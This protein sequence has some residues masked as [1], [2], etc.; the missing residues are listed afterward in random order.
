MNVDG[1]DLRQVTTDPKF[2]AEPVWSPD[3]GRIFF[4]TGRDRNFEIYAIN[5]DGSGEL[6]LTN[7]PAYEGAFAVAADGKHIFYLCGTTG[8]N[9]LNQVCIMNTDGSGQRQLTSFSDKVDRAAYSPRAGK[10]VVTSKKDGN[11]EV[12]SMD[13]A[14]IPLN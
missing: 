8:K 9:E 10:F 4:I 5:I 11:H 2:D 14:N 12:F 1:S 7:N 13:A 3:G 6:N